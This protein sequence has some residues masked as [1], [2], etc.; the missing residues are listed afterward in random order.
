MNFFP[1]LIV[2][3][4]LHT[5]VFN[6]NEFCQFCFFSSP[7][8]FRIAWILQIS[9]FDKTTLA[10]ATRHWPVDRLNAP[11]VCTPSVRHVEPSSVLGFSTIFRDF[12]RY[13]RHFQ[14]NELKRN[15][16]KTDEEVTAARPLNSILFRAAFYCQSIS[17]ARN[18]YTSVSIWQHV[19]LCGLQSVQIQFKKVSPLS[20]YQK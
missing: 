9:S 1:Q 4:K 8:W 16:R 7:F 20:P 2:F 18:Q 13:L 17:R 5:N 10:T 19:I 12:P 11:S 6:L 15:P 3:G 14:R